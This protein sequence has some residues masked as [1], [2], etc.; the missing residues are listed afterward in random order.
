MLRFR[1]FIAIGLFAVFFLA[2]QETVFPLGPADIFCPDLFVVLAIC[3][4][5]V[6]GSPRALVASFLCGLLWD[7]SIGHALGF[8]ASAC[9]LAFI[10]AGYLS[11]RVYVSS[12]S[13]IF[14]LGLFSALISGIL[15][16]LLASS[17]GSTSF[18]LSLVVLVVLESLSSAVILPFCYTIFKRAYRSFVLRVATVATSYSYSSQV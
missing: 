4:S 9:L 14:F 11:S 6:V 8:E 3:L 13:S 5:L 12:F 15:K 10:T 16:S 7:L 18:N 1:S 17:Y 2:V